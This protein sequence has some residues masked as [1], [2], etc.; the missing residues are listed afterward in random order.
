M[1]STLIIW[2]KQHTPLSFIP[3]HMSHKTRLNS[4][5]YIG[6]VYS[7]L[8]WRIITNTDS[9]PTMPPLEC[10]L[11]R[12]NISNPGGKSE[13]DNLLKLSCSIWTLL[14]G[15]H[16]NVSQ[17]A[18]G[19]LAETAHCSV[20][21]RCEIWSQR[22]WLCVSCHLCVCV[23][24]CVHA[25]MCMC[26]CACVCVCVCVYVCVHACASWELWMSGYGQFTGQGYVCIWNEL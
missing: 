19:F 18:F 11:S 3:N 22:N 24:A 10:P 7:N 13:R 2:K 9:E 15:L 12:Y 26:V 20:T 1:L 14:T 4:R 5:R 8:D 21:L 25:C 16:M 23:C 6:Y 17:I